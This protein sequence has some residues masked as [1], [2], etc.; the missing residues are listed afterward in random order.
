MHDAAFVIR[1]E[2]GAVVIDT[3]SHY[4]RSNLR[5]RVETADAAA[6]I[7]SKAHLPHAA[8]VHALQSEYDLTIITS[9]K[10]T[11]ILGL[12][13]AE[14][15]TVGATMTV[16]G[17]RFTFVK[18]P[19]KDIP[20]SAWIYAHDQ[21]TLF[22]ADGF[23]CYHRPGDCERLAGDFADGLSSERLAEYH[24][25]TLVW[26]RY[27]DAD[28]VNNEIDALFEEQDIECVAPNHGHP[29]LG[30]ELPGYRERMRSVIRTLC[31]EFEPP[32]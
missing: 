30:E 17:D 21:R 11:E 25:D 29:I 19:L 27:A 2:A 13:E 18:P 16:A 10:A 9:G 32:T 15:G 3:G 4:N 1:T 20:H 6:V 23:G 31:K 7:M 8:N 24:R 5:E 28:A 22:S 26:L 14:V 12:S